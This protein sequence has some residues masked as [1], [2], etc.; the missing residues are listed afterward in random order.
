MRL[1]PVL[2]PDVLRNLLQGLGLLSNGGGRERPVREPYVSGN[3][4][5][6]RKR[7][8]R[9][10]GSHGGGAHRAA[11]GV[12]RGLDTLKSHEQAWARFREVSLH[13]FPRQVLLEVNQE[14][15]QFCAVPAGRPTGAA[16]SA[17]ARQ[18]FSLQ[19]GRHCTANERRTRAGPQKAHASIHCDRRDAG[20]SH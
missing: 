20:A 3:K 19:G 6:R 15:R 1:E 17:R 16:V 9:G 11:Y 13:R 7:P 12:S 5:G 8:A 2:C 4:S 18:G 10:M 14:P